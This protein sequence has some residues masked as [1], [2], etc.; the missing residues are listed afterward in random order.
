V[1]T[2]CEK[3]GEAKKGNQTDKMDR[4]HLNECSVK[5]TSAMSLLM[6]CCDKGSRDKIMDNLVGGGL[7]QHNLFL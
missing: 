4:K 3:D 7:Q 1:I 5:E 2:L 6:G